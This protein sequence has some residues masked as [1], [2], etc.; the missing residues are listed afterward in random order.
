MSAVR[1]WSLT[2]KSIVASP[3][4]FF[5]NFNLRDGY[6]YPVAYALVS[7]AVGAVLFGLVL[8]VAAAAFGSGGAGT[9]LTAGAVFGAV[10]FALS[11]VG[12]VTRVLAAHVVV[13]LTESGPF[14]RTLEAFAYPT[15]ATMALGGVP[16]VGVVAPLYGYYLQYKGL[17]SFQGLEQGPAAAAIVVANVVSGVI[18]TVFV[19]VVLPLLV[20]F[21]G[22][23]ALAALG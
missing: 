2:T 6:G 4:F 17:A 5:E 8:A 16:V 22:L 7:A 11:V 3:G 15:V 12:F 23:A 14:V 19:F 21:V 18:L 10:A 1:R 9:A 20:A 13:A